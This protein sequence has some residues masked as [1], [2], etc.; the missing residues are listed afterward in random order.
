MKPVLRIPMTA[1]YWLNIS[2]KASSANFT[3]FYDLGDQ[4]KTLISNMVS[5]FTEAGAVVILDLHWS[6]DDTEQR[7][8]PVNDGPTAAHVFWGSVS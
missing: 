8:M 5:T 3:R 2:T 6:D 4:Y 1:S 7:A